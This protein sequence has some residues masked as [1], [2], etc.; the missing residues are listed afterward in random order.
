[1]AG[2]VALVAA[3]AVAGCSQKNSPTNPYGSSTGGG[4]GG[5]ASGNGNRPFD[6]STMSSPATFVRVFP[7]ADSVGYH[8]NFHRN[9][10]MVG[11][12]IVATG[13]AD[14]A[15]VNLT[16]TSFAPSKVRI[17]PGGYVHWKVLDGTHTVTSD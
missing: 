16:G 17:K 1:M 7:A 12:V 5:G 15:V 6:S 14:S 9:M 10:G 11:T 4:G 13:E 2:A 8:C 3:G